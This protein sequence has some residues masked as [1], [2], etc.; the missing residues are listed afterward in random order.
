MVLNKGDNIQLSPL[1][2]CDPKVCLSEKSKVTR[3]LARV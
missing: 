2:E 3:E 1:L